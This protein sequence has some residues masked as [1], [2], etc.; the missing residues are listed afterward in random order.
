MGL[1]IG[2][3]EYGVKAV[4]PYTNEASWSARLS[5]VPRFFVP[6]SPASL[7]LIAELTADVYVFRSV[8]MLRPEREIL[9][10]LPDPSVE[11]D[12]GTYFYNQDTVYAVN[13]K[14]GEVSWWL[15]TKAPAVA[16]HVLGD[17]ITSEERY[18]LAARLRDTIAC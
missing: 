13:R 2:R 18:T 1:L 8:R 16:V 7:V 14:T 3:Y 10:P 15:D 9:P 12:P 11:L 5:Y 4:D 17:Q 6:P